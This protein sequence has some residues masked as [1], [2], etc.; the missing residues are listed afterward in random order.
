MLSFINSR[1]QQ[2]S[3]NTQHVGCRSEYEIKNISKWQAF[4]RVQIT[5]VLTRV[6]TPIHQDVSAMTE[7]EREERVRTARAWPELRTTD[8]YVLT[9]TVP[10][11]ITYYVCTYNF[12]LARV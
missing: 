7:C 1:D 8:S 10:G 3:T 11:Y 9:V 2:L 5:R 4:S 6:I 12:Y